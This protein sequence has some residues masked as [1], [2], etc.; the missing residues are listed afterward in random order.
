MT[1][2]THAPQSLGL[3]VNAHARR[4]RRDFLPKD[5]FWEGLLSDAAVRITST[6]PELEDAVME[7]VGRGIDV[8]AC[9][10]GDGTM[11]RTVG[12]LLRLRQSESGPSVLP[13]AGGTLNGLAHA[14]GTAGKPAQTLRLALAVAGTGRL[15]GRERRLLNVRSASY[16]APL[17]G[18]TFAAGLPARAAKIYYR[19][20]NPGVLDAVRVSL[21]PVT[22]AVLGGGFYAPTR[23]EVTIDGATPLSEPHTIVAGVVENP[24]LWFRPFGPLRRDA[25]GFHV[26]V[27][28]MRPREI[29]P[30]LWKMYSG[31]C[32]HPRLYTGTAEAATIRGE[33]GFVIDGEWFPFHEQFEV[34]L[35][36]GPVIRI[37]DA[38]SLTSPDP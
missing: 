29:A 30:R 36:S 11:H 13:M 27:A 34:Q 18:F 19:Q 24:F 32:S 25:V 6:L 26:T 38:A 22:A 16:G 35:T 33:E 17:Y 10:G 9:L 8:V 5:R 20:A 4:V 28:S 37:L 2:A 3:I 21:I 14:H 23:L 1:H 31:R 7:F 15:T 12:A